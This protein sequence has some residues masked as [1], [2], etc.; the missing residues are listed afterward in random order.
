MKANGSFPVA[1]IFGAAGFIGRNL[2]S[3]FS[4]NNP[5]TVGVA[6]NAGNGLLSLDLLNPDVSL[7]ELKRRGVSHAVIAAGASKIAACEEDPVSTRKV[8]TQ[9]TVELATQ[10][11]DQGIKVIALSSDYVFD[12]TT[13]HY[14]EASPVS[15]VNEYGRQKAEMEKLLLKIGG[16]NVLILRLSKV[17][18]MIKGSRTLLDEMAGMLTRGETV[19]VARDQ[20]F[21]PVWVNDVVNVIG[22]LM[23]TDANGVMHLCA[24]QKISRFEL[25]RNIAETFGV[26]PNLVKSISLRN[27]GENFL[28]PLDTS[29]VCDRLGHYVKYA[30]KDIHECIKRL[31][32]N[33]RGNIHD[34]KV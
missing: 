2:L 30:F 32:L 28:R 24:P 20:F 8:N 18:D 14:G 17:F 27:L 31:A 5:R 15:P 22:R 29:M 26:N 34:E 10:L 7:L 9:G 21:C 19:S 4:E 1:A 16:E 11:C 33:Y 3:K 25:A 6:R 23:D 13:G 12:G